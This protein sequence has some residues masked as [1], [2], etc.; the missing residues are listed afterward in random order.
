MVGDWLE[1]EELIEKELAEREALEDMDEEA[2]LED[3][4]TEDDE[5][6][7][8][9]DDDDEDDAEDEGD[10]DDEEDDAAVEDENELVVEALTEEMPPAPL[11]EPEL[12]L[13]A[14]EVLGEVPPSE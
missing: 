14:A 1:L 2:L 4:E 13:A 6:D 7:T 3:D 10:T 5:D 8:E 11:A 12:E 9:N